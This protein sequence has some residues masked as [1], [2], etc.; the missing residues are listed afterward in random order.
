MR[1][2]VEQCADR[3]VQFLVA[4]LEQLDVII[5]GGCMDVVQAA[6]VAGPLFDL[7]LGEGGAKR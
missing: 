6:V 7:R 3:F 2:P 4:V 5:L 1:I